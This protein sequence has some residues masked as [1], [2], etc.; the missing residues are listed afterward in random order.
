[1]T[2]KIKLQLTIPIEIEMA[3]LLPG[4]EFQFV[5]ACMKNPGNDLSDEE[6]RAWFSNLWREQASFQQELLANPEYLT[7]FAK[8][9]VLEELENEQIPSATLEE[10]IRPIAETLNKLAHFSP[11]LEETGVDIYTTLGEVIAAAK[12]WFDDPSVSIIEIISEDAASPPIV[13]KS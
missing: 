7:R 1:M 4:G 10:V 9:L 5:S 12:L 13:T 6:N 11:V 3:H 2:T 8:Y